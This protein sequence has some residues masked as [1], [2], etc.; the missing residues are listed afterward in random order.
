[1]PQTIRDE[2][3]LPPNYFPNNDIS[4]LD[5]GSWNMTLPSQIVDRSGKKISE[6]EETQRDGSHRSIL[7]ALDFNREEHVTSVTR[8]AKASS[9]PG[10]TVILFNFLS[11][12]EQKSDNSATLLSDERVKEMTALAKQ[13][14][15]GVKVVTHV[16]FGKP[17]ESLL[18][19]AQK[20]NCDLIILGKRK[21]RG[22]KKLT[23]TSVSNAIVEKASCSVTIA[24]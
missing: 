19:V 22:V 2:H 11:D 20:H 8:E 23:T 18:G 1:M 5:G 9:K 13:F 21:L 4:A 14:E 24:K 10:D 6:S 7:A 17:E 16:V 12:R 15:E 3:T